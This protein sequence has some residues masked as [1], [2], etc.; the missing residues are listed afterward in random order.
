MYR[1]PFVGAAES[2]NVLGRPVPAALEV[3][4]GVGQGGRG[5]RHKNLFDNSKRADR[6]LV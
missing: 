1:K 4:L 5:R 2:E 6:L 3:A